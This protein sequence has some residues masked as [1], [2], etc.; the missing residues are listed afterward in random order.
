VL[1]R[2]REYIA[3]Y[4]S[5]L[6]KASIARHLSL[7]TIYIDKHSCLDHPMDVL[8]EVII[9]VKYYLCPDLI[10]LYQYYI[11]SLA[12]SPP[13]RLNRNG[14]STRHFPVL[15]SRLSYMAKKNSFR[16]QRPLQT[17]REMALAF[18]AWHELR[19]FKYICFESMLVPGKLSVCYYLRRACVMVTLSVN[20]CIGRVIIPP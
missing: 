16:L 11:C 5:I 17:S 7:S 3:I 12:F 6:S 4:A 14:G 20:T 2:G 9:Y 1:R 19:A 8:Q 15:A 13:C 18:Y 10:D